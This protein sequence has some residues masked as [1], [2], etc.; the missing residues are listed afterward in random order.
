M[1][2]QANVKSWPLTFDAAGTGTLVASSNTSTSKATP[3]P[4]GPYTI[5]VTQRSTGTSIAAANV[6]WQGSNDNL[7]WTPLGSAT[8]LPATN[9]GTTN[10]YQAAGVAI[11]TSPFAFGR[12]ILASTGTG[13]ASVWMGV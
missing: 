3:L 1:F 6:V 7:G 4:R 2:D 11:A 10:T 13:D 5:Q 9:A 8:T 12:A